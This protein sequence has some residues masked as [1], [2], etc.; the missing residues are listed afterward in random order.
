MS[1]VVPISK[2]RTSYEK[3][4]EIVKI[5]SIALKDYTLNPVDLLI[6]FSIV[7]SGSIIQVDT[8]YK[9]KTNIKS[10]SEL[11][12]YF[13]DLTVAFVEEHKVK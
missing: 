7:F 9:K 12:D 3:S 6:A 4:Q 1:K 8:E 11:C 10:V 5:V 2:G 13:K